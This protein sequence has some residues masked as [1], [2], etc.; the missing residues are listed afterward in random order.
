[1][2]PTV[3][4]AIEARLGGDRPDAAVAV[5]FGWAVLDAS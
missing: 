3:A 5:Y 4:E 2:N 1:M